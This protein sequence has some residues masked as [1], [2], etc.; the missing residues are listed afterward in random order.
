MSGQIQ[1]A[2]RSRL[3]SLKPSKS[4]NRTTSFDDSELYVGEEEEEEKEGEY[5]ELYEEKMSYTSS[6]TPHSC[7]SRGVSTETTEFTEQ[8]PNLIKT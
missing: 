3:L 6:T 1:E 8:K 2:P 4:Q 5:E 7:C